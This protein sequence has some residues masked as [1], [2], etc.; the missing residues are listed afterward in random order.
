MADGE[1]SVRNN[2]WMKAICV[3]TVLF[4][5]GFFGLFSYFTF[6]FEIV[7]YLRRFN[8]GKPEDWSLIFVIVACAAVLPTV[9]YNLRTFNIER[10]RS[11][12]H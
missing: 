9:V 2:F 1:F 11:K 6:K 4:W 12:A 7:D 5:L 3:V 8:S 10:I